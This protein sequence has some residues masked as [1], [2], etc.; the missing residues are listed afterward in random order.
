MLSGSDSL[1]VLPYSVVFLTRK[2]TQIEALPLKI[3]HPNRQL[4]MLFPCESG[5]APALAPF[6]TFIAAQCRQLE[7]RIQHDQQVTR[8]RG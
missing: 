2:T 5:S 1:T 3:E 4:G 6:K 8:R 7:A